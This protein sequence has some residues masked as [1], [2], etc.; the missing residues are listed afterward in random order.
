MCVC[1]CMCLFGVVMSAFGSVCT[2]NGEEHCL[3]FVFAA[4]VNG[5]V[6]VVLSPPTFHVNY[7]PRG[8]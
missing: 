2:I 5:M 3:A 8:G 7:K 6:A 4:V 1:V